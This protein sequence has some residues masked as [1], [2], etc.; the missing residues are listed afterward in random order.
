MV[1]RQNHDSE[2]SSSTPLEEATLEEFAASF[3]ARSESGDA[4]SRTLA[5]RRDART[6]ASARVIVRVTMA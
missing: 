4:L 6:R 1:D 3:A 2:M 5:R